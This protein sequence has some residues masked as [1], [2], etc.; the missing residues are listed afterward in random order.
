[1]KVD[2]Q[3]SRL[4]PGLL[5]VAIKGY[6]PETVDSNQILKFPNLHSAPELLQVP[7]LLIDESEVSV[8]TLGLTRRQLLVIYEGGIAEDLREEMPLLFHGE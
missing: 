2:E 8:E 3:V 7:I 4:L 1:M 5:I 6:L